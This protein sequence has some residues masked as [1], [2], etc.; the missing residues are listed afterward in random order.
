M[1]YKCISSIVMQS[2]CQ[3]GC[4]RQDTSRDSCQKLALLKCH[5]HIQFLNV[6]KLH[7]KP[8]LTFTRSGLATGNLHMC[9]SLVL[10]LEN[11]HIAGK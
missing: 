1:F 11:E 5:F 4:P 2:V 9:V 6:C 8:L 7:R 10:N 3:N